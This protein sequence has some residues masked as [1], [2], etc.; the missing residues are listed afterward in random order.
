MAAADVERAGASVLLV[1]GCVIRSCL[2]GVGG[3][4]GQSQVPHVLHRLGEARGH[5]PHETQD[6][7][8][9]RQSTHGGT[10]AAPW[11]GAIRS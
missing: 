2:G 7:E 10:I 9:G 8:A 1:V 11:F 5:H 3:V 6:E 4:A